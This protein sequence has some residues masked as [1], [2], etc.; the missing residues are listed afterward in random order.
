MQNRDISYKENWTFPKS[1][2]QGKF[3]VPRNT[4]I[5]RC[6]TFV[7]TGHFMLYPRLLS[8]SL[9]FFCSFFLSLFSIFSSL[10]LSFKIYLFTLH[11]NISPPSPP[12]TSSHRSSPLPLPPPLWYPAP[13]W[14]SSPPAYQVT[15][16]PSAS[17]EAKQGSPEERAGER[18]QKLVGGGWEGRV[19]VLKH[20]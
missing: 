8:L 12:S 16:G 6:N 11:R 7:H 14:V 4:W 2:S 13:P 17:T 19:C 5:S 3:T 1:C 20:L 9:L 15:V 10:F 18:E